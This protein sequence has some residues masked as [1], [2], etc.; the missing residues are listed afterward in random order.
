[1]R[2]FI[3]AGCV[4]VSLMSNAQQ[5]TDVASVDL[6][7]SAVTAEVQWVNFDSDPWLD[8]FVFAKTQSGE[9]FFITCKSNPERGPVNPTAHYL[10]FHSAT[11][12]IAD[13]DRDNDMD[14]I[15]SGIFANAP[16]T[17]FF[18]NQ[19]DFK[20]IERASIAVAGSALHFADLNGNGT[21][22]LMISGSENAL[23][24]FN[25][26]QLGTTWKL[27]HDS[28]KVHATS[29]QVFDF[30][31]DSDNDIFIAGKENNAHVTK[32]LINEGGLYFKSS[33]ASKIVN[34]K[35]SLADLNHDGR[36]DIFVTGLNTSGQ[37]ASVQFLNQDGVFVAKDTLVPLS[38]NATFLA[39]FN[40]DGKCDIHSMGFNAAG[41]TLNR[42]FI[43]DSVT[44]DLNKSRLH[45]QAFGDYDRDGDLDL[46]QVVTGT[47][48]LQLHTWRNKARY[49]R[50]PSPPMGAFGFTI[51]NKL[52]LYWNPAIDDHTPSNAI[53]YDVTL[54][55]V[56]SELQVGDFDMFT[57]ERLVV[58]HGNAGTRNYLLLKPQT[59]TPF[60]Y[61]VQSV[62][63][64]F[65]SPEEAI[66]GGRPGVCEG[67]AT[68]CAAP[69]IVKVP[70]CKNETLTFTAEGN[71]KWFSLSKGFLEEG[72]TFQMEATASDTVFSFTEIEGCASL[73]I[74]LIE[75]KK[76][77]VK[78][79]T[80][81]RFVC[82][83]QMIDLSSESAWAQVQW[84]SLLKG[85]LGTA[86]SIR[87]TATQ[88]DTV[89]L[90]AS[91]TE[92]CGIQHKTALRISKPVITL[93][94]EAYQVLKGESVQL[95]AGGGERY[96][97][98]PAETLDNST[99]ANPIASPLS[100]TTY[101][102]TAYDSIGCSASANVHVNVEGTAFIPNLFTPND[103]GKND[104]VKVYGLSQ[105]SNFS[106]AIHNREGNVL[107]ET[108]DV[109]QVSN[110]GWDG[111][112]NGVKQPAGVYYWKVKGEHPSG[113]RLLLNGKTNG[114]IV[115]I[116]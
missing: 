95:S 115:L 14:V 70:A 58:S 78:K 67:T 105:V 19:G 68:P 94:G 83:G 57:T 79:S 2:S 102:V 108:K 53:T 59:V 30:D 99:I 73:K 96:Q 81:T 56:N 82:E 61:A 106:F 8:V 85:N 15:V 12:R 110:S 98:A 64:S 63:N 51:F 7:D 22:E 20:F 80:E 6:P 44:V 84:T 74:Y 114:S 76:N 17:A 38:N 111:T 27:V 36:L 18:E 86:S 69:E 48:K 88:P 46:V 72:L 13:F 49:N 25:I 71:P 9:N 34:G 24:F 10:G 100:S 62:D 60:S 29:I 45:H 4:L 116:R 101:T 112:A 87:Y 43:R 16:K 32:F 91:N 89:T 109:S 1:M 55:T 52:F 31:G 33:P 90:T 103:D 77:F 21:G 66:P 41:D 54:Q 65:E 47:G 107:Y 39:D 11:Y 75:I 28:L 40:S 3:L 104:E 50:G 97:W 23:A 5:F 42:I 93:E 26:Y 37:N 113:R 92:G 35:S